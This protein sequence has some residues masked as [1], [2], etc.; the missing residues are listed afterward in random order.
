MRI[1]QWF[2]R[3]YS[4]VYKQALAV[5]DILQGETNCYK[6]TIL[7]VLTKFR[8]TSVGLLLTHANEYRVKLPEKFIIR[9]GHLLDSINYKIASVTHPAFKQYWASTEKEKG[10]LKLALQSAF[11]IDELS[12]PCPLSVTNT[13]PT[14]TDFLNLQTDSLPVSKPTEL[15]LGILLTEE[16]IWQCWTITQMLKNCSS[17]IIQRYLQVLL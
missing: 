11:Q 3:N 15:D 17:D 14:I 9:L 12:S 8:K 10:L 16:K 2:F 4:V 5:L 7:P 6:G 1:A 13:S